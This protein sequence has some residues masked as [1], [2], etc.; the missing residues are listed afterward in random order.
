MRRVIL[1]L[2]GNFFEA[3]VGAGNGVADVEVNRRI[4]PADVFPVLDFAGENAM[5]LLGG[6]VGQGIVRVN[7]DRDAVRADDVIVH[8][9]IALFGEIQIG[10]DGGPRGRRDVALAHAQCGHAIAGGF[11]FDIESDVGVLLLEL[12]D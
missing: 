5:D 2:H 10:G 9:Q 12:G 3:E 1:V 7:H 11:R 8:F 4:R 6:Q